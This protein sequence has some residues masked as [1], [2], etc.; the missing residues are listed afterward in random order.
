M[1]GSPRATARHVRQGTALPLL[2]AAVTPDVPAVL[3]SP[4]DVNTASSYGVIICVGAGPVQRMR[5]L[6]EKPG[7]T[8]ACQLLAEHSACSLRCRAACA[9][10]GNC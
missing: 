6:V 10:H 9:S 7:R 3:A 2:A 5:G 8:E 4:F 1:G